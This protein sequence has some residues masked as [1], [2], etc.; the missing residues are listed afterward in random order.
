[1]TIFPTHINFLIPEPVFM[2]ISVYNT[3]SVPIP[4]A[5]VMHFTI[6]NT[7]IKASQVAEAALIVEAIP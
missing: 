5:D 6:S 2:K 7:N 1:M 3:A 4:M